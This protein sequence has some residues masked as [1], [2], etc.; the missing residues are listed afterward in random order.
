MRAV[1]IPALMFLSA[2][3][4]LP[5]E[6]E[7]RVTGDN[8]EPVRGLQQEDFSIRDGGDRT[9]ETFAFV[10]DPATTKLYI[11]VQ[12]PANQFPRVRQAIEAFLDSGL[13]EGMEVS[14]G[15]APFTADRAEF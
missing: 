6:V 7:V 8:R 3:P 12:T 11:A 10:D 2:S 15:G 1:I 14:M 5:L 13:P 4:L 9:I